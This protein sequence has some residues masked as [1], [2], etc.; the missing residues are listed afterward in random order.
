MSM[1]KF[2]FSSYSVSD[3]TPLKLSEYSGLYCLFFLQP[4]QSLPIVRRNK[5]F[6][7]FI[8]KRKKCTYWE[9]QADPTRYWSKDEE[10]TTAARSINQ[11]E[12]RLEEKLLESGHDILYDE[13]GQLSFS[14]HVC[15]LACG[16]S[17]QFYFS[18][19]DDLEGYYLQ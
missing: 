19:L 10:I 13:W 7:I 6:H 4:L 8:P 2:L 18:F 14:F 16:V 15:G 9:N 11:T 5:S 12:I 17:Q 1:I 3:K